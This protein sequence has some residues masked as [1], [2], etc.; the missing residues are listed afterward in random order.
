MAEMRV[1]P[2]CR[3]PRT[4][5]ARRAYEVVCTA[6]TVICE[7]IGKL[8]AAKYTEEQVLGD[9]FPGITLTP[10]PLPATGEREEQK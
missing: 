9:W 2:V 7:M 10:A 5:R 3:A 4:D 1:G 6:S 8:T